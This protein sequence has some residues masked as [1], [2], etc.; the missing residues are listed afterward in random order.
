M[1]TR[2]GGAASGTRT[3][4]SLHPE[5]GDASHLGDNG[6][7]GSAAIAIQ[8][9]AVNPA[10][11][12]TVRR[13]DVHAAEQKD[14]AKH[15]LIS[16]PRPHR[17]ILSSGMASFNES[18]ATPSGPGWVMRPVQK[19]LAKRRGPEGLGGRDS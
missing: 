5:R 12:Q 16:S 10:N 1:D 3:R 17:V 8:L 14:V 19:A 11:W 2:V 6:E 4:R 7:A 18:S 15:G 13:A 9:D